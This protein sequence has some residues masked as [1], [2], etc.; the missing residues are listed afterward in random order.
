[1]FDAPNQLNLMGFNFPFFFWVEEHIAKISQVQS[2]A[3]IV[4]DG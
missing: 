4:K 2:D 3:K 1:M